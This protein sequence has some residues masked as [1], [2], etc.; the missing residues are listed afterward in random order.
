MVAFRPAGAAPPLRAAVLSM[1][2]QAI[3][4]ISPVELTWLKYV[5]TAAGSAGFGKPTYMTLPRLVFW[6]MPVS[7]R[8]VLSKSSPAPAP[9]NGELPFA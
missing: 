4:G 9:L 1:N 7:S 8:R 5:L 6:A 3:V 2:A